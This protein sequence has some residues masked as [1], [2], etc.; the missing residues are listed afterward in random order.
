MKKFLSFAV[1]LAVF[2]FANAQQ[3]T[4]FEEDFE[5]YDDFIIEDIGDWLNI[6]A[7]GSSDNT[8]FADVNFPNQ[9]IANAWIVFNPYNTTPPIDDVTT[10]NWDFS[11][12]PNSG[13]KYMLAKFSYQGQ[14]SDWLISPQ[15]ELPEE[16]AIFWNFEAKA[17]SGF[18]PEESFSVWVSTTD[19]DLGSFTQIDAV[20][21]DDG[22]VWINY[23]YDISEFHG[24]SV[25]LAIEYTSNNLFALLIDNFWVYYEET[26][27]VTDLNHRNLLVYPN[28]VESE[29]KLKYPESDFDLNNLKVTLT[30]LTGKTIKTFHR[31]TSFDISELG[32]GIYIV[33]VN[34]GKTSLKTKII[35]K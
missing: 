5:A 31:E 12:I 25:Y 24:Q 33:E 26:A 4:I 34:D 21:M 35:K 16:S 8:G 13:E 23:S 6:N 17:P 22:K 10:Y 15:I 14:N 11:P 28:P 2:S 3:V 1:Y 27:G 9:E 7:D 18:F 29:F 20:T 32:K 19:T 30:D